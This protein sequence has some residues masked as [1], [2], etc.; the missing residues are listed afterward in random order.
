MRDAEP[1]RRRIGDPLGDD[2]LHART[3]AEQLCRGAIERCLDDLDTKKCGERF[4]DD[5]L[6]FAGTKSMQEGI[7]ASLRS[8]EISRILAPDT[9]QLLFDR[10]TRRPIRDQSLLQ[11]DRVLSAR[12]PRRTGTSSAR[13]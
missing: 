4:D 1:P 11:G 7:R 2:D 13:R 10:A 12:L 3:G 6:W 5:V 9:K 8:N